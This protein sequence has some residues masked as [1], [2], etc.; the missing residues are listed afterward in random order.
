M[1]KTPETDF[2]KALAE[3]RVTTVAVPTDEFQFIYWWR[4][5]TSQRRRQCEKHR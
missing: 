4:N 2:A 3:G 5:A 1:A